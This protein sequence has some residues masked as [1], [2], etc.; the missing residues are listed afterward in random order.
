MAKKFYC[1]ECGIELKHVRKTVQ[2]KAIIADMIYPHECQGFAVSE[3]P[4][5]EKTILQIINE[6]NE[7]GAII[8]DDD[9]GKSSSLEIPDARSPEHQ[10]SSTAPDNIIDRIKQG[11][12]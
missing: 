5:G 11:L 7:V 6:T 4:E 12:A 8:R 1:T 9:E 2:G 10:K 3:C